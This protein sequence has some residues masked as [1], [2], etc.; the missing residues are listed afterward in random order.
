[1]ITWSLRLLISMTLADT[2][3]LR[4]EQRS[5]LSLAGWC[6]SPAGSSLSSKLT[7][8]YFLTNLDRSWPIMTNL[9]QSWPIAALSRWIAALLVAEHQSDISAPPPLLNL[10]WVDL[11]QMLCLVI[12][13]WTDS[14]TKDD[15][16]VIKWSNPLVAKHLDAPPPLHWV[17]FDQIPRLNIDQMIIS[18]SNDHT[19]DS[20][21][22][23]HKNV[24]VL[25]R[26]CI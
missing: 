3:S 6:P 7:Q 14:L 16:I 12:I 20:F 10:D 5:S 1:M 8:K 18:L 19:T 15:H 24:E 11:D 17:E 2:W 4:S 26:C 22:V 25:D 13:S 23:L 9:D 21:R